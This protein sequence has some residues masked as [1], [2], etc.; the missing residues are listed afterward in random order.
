MRRVLAILGAVAMITAAVFLRHHLDDNAAKGHE[1]A[2]DQVVIVCA[3]DLRPY[4][5][6]L[7]ATVRYETAAVTADELKTGKLADDVD[8]WITS[9]AWLEVTDTADGGKPTGELEALAS[10]PVAASAADGPAGQAVVDLCRGQRLWACLG[11]NAGQSWSAL[12]HPTVPGSLDVGVTDADTALGL[13]VLASIGGGTFGNLDY[14]SN[15][16]GGDFPSRIAALKRPSNGTDPTPLTTMIT[17][18]GKYAAASSTKA[19][20]DAVARPVQPVT[21]DPAVTATVVLVRI[22]GGDDLPS[23]DPVRQALVADGWSKANGIS[24]PPTLKDGVMSA[25]HDVWTEAH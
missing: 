11:A 15:D 24:V 14:A 2:D 10:S 4:C 22:P 19:E 18:T 13:P 3:D 8:G 6:G 17:Q 23:G 16:F 5:D 25:L 7:D 12:G 21:L 9:S 1:H 20:Q